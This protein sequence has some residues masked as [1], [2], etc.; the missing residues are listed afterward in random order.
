MKFQ[1]WIQTWFSPNLGQLFSKYSIVLILLKIRVF[2]NIFSNHSKHIKY[3]SIYKNKQLPDIKISEIIVVIMYTTALSLNYGLLK[4]LQEYKNWWQFFVLILLQLGN[5]QTM[6]M[7]F[8]MF[9]TPSPPVW[10]N[11]SV[12]QPPL[13]SMWI[14]IC[15]PPPHLFQ[16]Y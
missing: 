15:S 12:G 13:I 4:I 3:C 1:S 5:I 10:M 14:F 2:L 9:S 6:W 8:W 7:D 16:K 11:V